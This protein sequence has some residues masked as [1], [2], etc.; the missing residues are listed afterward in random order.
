MRCGACMAVCPTYQATGEEAMVAR[1]RLRLVEA[2]LDGQLG[3]TGGLAERISKCI[4]CHACESVCPSGVDVVE[5]LLATRAELAAS[6]RHRILSRAATRRAIGGEQGVPPYALRLLATMEQAAYAKMPGFRLL[7]YWR[8]GG[9]RSFPAMQPKPLTELLPERSTPEKAVGRVAFYPGCAINLFYPAT[10]LALVE[11]LN[12]AGIEVIVPR[13]WHCCG[14]PFRSLGDAATARLMAEANLQA[15]SGLEVDA[16][17][18]ACSTCALAL[19]RDLPRLLEGR[20]DAAALAGSVMDVHEYLA[21]LDSPLSLAGPDETVRVTYHDPCHLRWGLEVTEE[22]REIIRQL[23]GVEYVEMPGGGGCC[24]GGGFFSL[25][26]YDL[27]LKIG[28]RR[29]EDIAAT[30]AQVVATGCPG[31][32]THLTDVLRRSGSQVR[33]VHTVELMAGDV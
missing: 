16:I 2:V 20:D 5:V 30:G 3:L 26:H 6:G 23:P 24:G 7:P 25:F 33:V 32:R 13:S 14:L 8:P 9:K 10:G 18:T 1:G 28:N 4:G 17:V 22:P 19:R 29:A 27:S 31:C 11:V 12:G 21:T 15:M